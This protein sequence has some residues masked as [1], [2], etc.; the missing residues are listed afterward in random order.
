MQVSLSCLPVGF[1][2]WPELALLHPPPQPSSF[3]AQPRLGR[4]LL[5]IH[6]KFCFSCNL[7][8]CFVA[9]SRLGLPRGPQHTQGCHSLSQLR[10]GAQ[11]AI[12]P[13]APEPGSAWG[14]LLQ[15]LHLG[16]PL[17]EQQSSNTEK[18][19]GAKSNCVR[20]QVVKAWIQKARDQKHPA[21]TCEEPGAKAGGRERKQVT[22]HAYPLHTAPVR[23]GQ[24]PKLPCKPDP[25][26][27]PCPH[28]V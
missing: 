9:S 6:P 5:L 1:S 13:P 2:E 14:L 26:T 18:P 20:A 27:L 23:G 10:R 21:A 28:P 19:H 22:V 25:W 12:S 11:G 8:P 17:L 15:Y 16:T 4:Q 7:L 3:W 24:P